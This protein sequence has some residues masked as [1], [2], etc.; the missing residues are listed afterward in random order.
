MTALDWLGT[1]DFVDQTE[2][3]DAAL[4]VP[5]EAALS[6]LP[7]RTSGGRILVGFPAVRRALARTPLGALPALLLYLPGV[8]RLGA[9]AYAW[10]AANRRRDAV[11][12][13]ETG[14]PPGEHRA[15]KAGASA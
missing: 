6:G 8:N 14:G 3:P 4:P 7:M 1:L 10:V 13:A 11:C 5:R 2:I 9:R 12:R 15:A